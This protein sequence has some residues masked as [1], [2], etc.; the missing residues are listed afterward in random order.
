MTTK[1]QVGD[2]VRYNR[3]P[4]RRHRVPDHV[5]EEYRGRTR[6]VIGIIHD[7]PNKRV[8]YELGEKGGSRIGYVFRSHQLVLVTPRQ[9]GT[10]GPPKRKR[11]RR[12]QVM[13]RR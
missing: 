8:L 4:A 13:D 6:T 11:R 1:F 12:A 5:E 2:K 9:A 10:R 7:E 3:R